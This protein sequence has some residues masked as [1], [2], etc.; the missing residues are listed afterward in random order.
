MSPGAQVTGPDGSGRSALGSEHQLHLRD[1]VQVLVQHWK[2][3]AL[4]TAAV[5]VAAYSS[6]RRAVPRYRSDA[7]FQI[8]SKKTG[9]ARLDEPNVNELE[10]QTD[11]VLSE[12]LI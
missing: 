7:S 10:L 2:V 6:A 11:P 4:V 8:G 12:A 9:A 1:V 5:S 3:V